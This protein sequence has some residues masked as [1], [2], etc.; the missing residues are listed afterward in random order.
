MPP[1]TQKP[2]STRKNQT[3]ASILDKETEGLGVR[4]ARGKGPGPEKEAV[5][6]GYQ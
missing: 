3:A 5:G 6:E 2:A 1:F 4:V